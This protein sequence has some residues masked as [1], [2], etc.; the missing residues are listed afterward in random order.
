[1][2]DI[3]RDPALARLSP[4]L[5]GLLILKAVMGGLCSRRMQSALRSTAIPPPRGNTWTRT[6]LTAAL[7]TLIRLELVDPSGR[8]RR[9]LEHELAKRNTALHP[10]LLRS[11]GA[12]STPGSRLDT[13]DLRLRLAVYA[14]DDAAIADIRHEFARLRTEWDEKENGPFLRVL[15]GGEFTDLPADAA[16]AAALPPLAAGVVLDGCLPE[17]LLK[18]RV[19]PVLPVLPLSGLG[20]DAAGA[21]FLRLLFLVLCG[22]MDEAERLPSAGNAV[23]ETSAAQL[24]G[25]CAF[26]RGR[27]VEAAQ[28][29][30][31]ARKRLRPGRKLGLERVPALC[32]IAALLADESGGGPDEARK[33]LETSDAFSQLGERGTAAAQ[34]LYSLA[35]GRREQAIGILNDLHAA[36]GDPVSELLLLAA[37][38]LCGRESD[39]VRPSVFEIL[40]LVDRLAADILN[41]KPLGTAAVSAEPLLDLRQLL[42]VR[43]PWERRLDDVIR[44]LDAAPHRE[45]RLVWLLHPDSGELEPLEQRGGPKGWS[46]G[47][48]A[49]LKRLCEQGEDET[50]LSA[51]D[52]R[53]LACVRWSQSWN[54]LH[55]VLDRVPSL[56][57]AVGHPLLFRAGDRRPVRLIREDTTLEIT[58]TGQELRLRLSRSVSSPSGG[59]ASELSRCSDDTYCVH[60]HPPYGAELEAALGPEG[61]VVPA[62]GI[63]RVLE[64]VRRSDVSVPLRLHTTG[65]T[66][67]TDPRPVL[68]L[69]PLGEGLAVQAAVR[70]FGPDGPAFVPGRGEIEPTILAGGMLVRGRRVFAD[71]EK[72]LE[73][74]CAACPLLVEGSDHEKARRCGPWNFPTLEGAL[75]LLVA[76]GACRAPHGLEWPEGRSLHPRPPLPPSALTLQ[77]QGVGDVFRLEGGLADGPDL[78][79]LLTGTAGRI[80]N[81]IPLGEGE[82]LTLTDRFRELLDR[83]A[84]LTEEDRDGARR[85]RA[86][87]APAL[88]GLL[89]EAGLAP[90]PACAEL[91]TA[92]REAARLD[93]L[94]PAGLR[95]ELRP[96]QREGFAWLY[97]LARWAGGACLADDM[98]L[99][100]TLQAAAL[101]LAEA[102]AGPSLVVAPLS[103]CRNWEQELAR[104]APDLRVYRP[105]PS[106]SDRRSLAASLGPGDVLVLSY[107]L[108]RSESILA[109]RAWNIIAFDEAQA[110]KNPATR[111][112]KAAR[113][114]SAR[115]R[116]ALTGTPVENR[117]DDLWSLFDIVLPGL[118]GS[119]PS[120]RRRFA[121]SE[122]PASRTG[123]RD[124]VRPFLLRRSKAAVLRELP[125]CTEQTLEVEFS[126]EERCFY[127]TLRRQAV[128]ELREQRDLPAGQRRVLIL[129]WLTR[130]RRAC[131][132]PSLADPACTLPGPK[133]AALTELVEELRAGGHRTLIFSQ[134]TGHLAPTRAELEQAGVKCLYLDGGTPERERAA[135]VS[136]FQNGEADVFLIS[137]RAGGQGL[138]LTAADYVI[139]LDP[140][141]NPAVEDQ[142]SNRAHRMGQERPVTVYRLIVRDSVEENILNLHA[143]K[144]RLAADVLDGADAALSE[145]ELLALLGA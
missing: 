119:L 19:A 38:V 139:H 53:I 108:L 40:P 33:L 14:G 84:V 65:E 63:S 88:A 97:R 94:P 51:Q 56:C 124:L 58:G 2:S 93:P 127:E 66:R 71:E 73:A 21:S 101:L 28:L 42:S 135:A 128:D 114:L 49:S 142:A 85:F 81:Y 131:C 112:T 36:P 87:A 1:M 126:P 18:G 116:L 75:D 79:L 77:V 11:L 37:Q 12:E 74:L 115:F 82:F 137:L 44:L 122:H 43:E 123:L 113:S 72:A 134:F 86:P 4:S 6:D 105:G 98:G 129:S 8:C 55:C 110:L 34:T 90:L 27:T 103:V 61:L 121:D 143:A 13:L 7:G 83:L 69:R 46:A 104:F 24:R 3:P 57:A 39:A 138:N 31:E 60:V 26:F 45:R 100:K 68:Q 78:S 59:R 120:F 62:A 111:Q 80:G 64:L 20:N 9:P 141:W 67:K 144:R 130:L 125:P 102:E 107:G 145:A 32:L 106:P 92:V 140:W 29:L 91:L 118:L 89:D 136:A 16:W 35:L 50:W 23:S 17:L 30:R 95:A 132:R 47:R 41:L 52:R 48:T 76:L 15:R 117:L 99:G 22:R 70:P 25:V 5:S 133:S 109:D 96:Y 54:G 10:A